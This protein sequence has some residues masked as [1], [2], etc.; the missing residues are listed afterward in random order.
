M[1]DRIG[2]C[3]EDLIAWTYRWL[4]VIG[5]RDLELHGCRDLASLVDIDSTLC[6]DL[7]IKDQPM[8]TRY[9]IG[10]CIPL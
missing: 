4:Y 8:F 3:G 1:A 5:V 2:E 7:C 6:Y 9:P 10:G